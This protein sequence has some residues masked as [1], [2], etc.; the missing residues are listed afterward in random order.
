MY[1]RKTSKPINIVRFYPQVILYFQVIKSLK[2]KGIKTFLLKSTFYFH[3]LI[4]II[5]FITSIQLMEHHCKSPSS[6]MIFDLLIPPKVTS[7]IIR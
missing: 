5:T 3:I 2:K 6:R 4:F 7:L 1:S